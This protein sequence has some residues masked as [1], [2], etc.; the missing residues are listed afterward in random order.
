MD[1]MERRHLERIDEQPP[2]DVVIQASLPSGFLG[3]LVDLSPIVPDYLFSC[4]TF[5][6]HCEAPEAQWY[7]QAKCVPAFRG[8]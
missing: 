5:S 8:F 6:D 3:I 7:Q 4:Q 1:S 2:H